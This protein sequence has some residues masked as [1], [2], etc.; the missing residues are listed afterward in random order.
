LLSNVFFYRQ[1]AGYFAAASET[2]PL[3]H[4]W[5]L[6][7]EE[8]FYLFFP[9]LLML[10]ARWK[11]N[12]FHKTIAALCLAAFARR[13]WICSFHKNRRQQ[14]QLSESQKCKKDL[15]G[16]RAAICGVPDTLFCVTKA[17]FLPNPAPRIP[18][19]FFHVVQTKRAI[20]SRSHLF[21]PFSATNGAHTGQL[22]ACKSGLRSIAAKLE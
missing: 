3:L 9:L 20:S 17:P 11:N 6:A 1:V 19:L 16:A 22:M 12:S 5:S 7:V 4:T 10:L 8:Q 21:P 18:S 13:R 14:A 2:K 15:T